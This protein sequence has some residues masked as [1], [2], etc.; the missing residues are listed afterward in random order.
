ML[1]NKATYTGF[2]MYC[3]SDTVGHYNGLSF[4]RS[5]S[6]TEG[7]LTAT[8][9]NTIIAR[10]DFLGCDSGNLQDY[11]AFIEVKQ[12]GA[13]G[14]KVPTDINFYTST[15]AAS[16]LAL[17][18]GTDKAITIPGAFNH[19]GTTFGALGAAPAAQQAH[20]AD[21]TDAA[22]VITRC[23]AILAALE[24]FGFLATA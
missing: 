18:I 17:T 23:N 7:T 16:A 14:A 10:L 21:A 20:I 1:I 3:F 12:N 9:T 24:T 13:A 2:N 22:T 5:Y 8:P 15:N 4:N 19:D 11:G 6:D